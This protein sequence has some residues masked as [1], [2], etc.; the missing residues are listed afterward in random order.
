MRRVVFEE[1]MDGICIDRIIRD[2]EYTMPSKHVHEEYEIYYL[3]EGERYYFIENQTYYVKE[4][5]LV[6]VNKGQIHKTGN[7][8]KSYHDRIL[9]E[10]KEEPFH[11]F[12][13]S[14]SGI[15]M[16]QFFADGYGVLQLDNAG[17]HMVKSLLFGIADEL[18]HKQP[19]YTAAAMMKLS[20]LFIFAV[21]SKIKENSPQPA[22]LAESSKHKKVS[23]V[24]SYIMSGATEAKSLDALAKRFYISKCYL[25][26]IFKEVTGFT[27]SEYVNINCVQKAQK[28]LLD[29][30][31][32]VTEIAD[33]LGYESITYFE[34]VF[35]KFTETSPL[36]YRKQYRKL[37]QP[38]RNKKQ[39]VEGN[40]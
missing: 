28:L 35:S 9:I 38:V 37:S 21:R 10:L 8:G 24:A 14:I 18:H 39:E 13:S 33:A 2:Y 12:L 40:P 4:G 32:S 17:Q 23:E 16:S 31:L 29:T 20:A 27:V 36:K 25:S 19:H 22:N 34:K 15:S 3:L 26:R 7:A 11:T 30:D 6:F 1:T 5:N